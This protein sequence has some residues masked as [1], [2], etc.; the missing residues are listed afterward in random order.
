[1]K[2][3]Y[4]PCNHPVW[5]EELCANKHWSQGKQIPLTHQAEREGCVVSCRQSCVRVSQRMLWSSHITPRG[6][7]VAQM[8]SVF[9]TQSDWATQCVY[10]H[11]V[12]FLSLRV[13]KEVEEK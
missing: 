9:N 3:L 2:S 13:D 8:R 7:E 12:A 10:T 5:L 4:D 11:T 1:M 6:Q